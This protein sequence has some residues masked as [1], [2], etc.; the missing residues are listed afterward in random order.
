M[1]ESERW[2]QQQVK[3]GAEGESHEV[4]K[5]HSDSVGGVVVIVIGVARISQI[6]MMTNVKDAIGGEGHQE[7]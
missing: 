5:P 7:C 1:F 6:L 3:D 4:E 2:D